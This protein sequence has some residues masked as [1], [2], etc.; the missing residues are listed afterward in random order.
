MNRN[1]WSITKFI[2]S[3]Y[4]RSSVSAEFEPRQ[5]QL[6]ILKETENVLT[7]GK[8]VLIELDCSL[9]KRY[10]QLALI[11]SVFPQK[12]IILI[13]QASTSLYE[14]YNYLKKYHKQGNLTLIDSRLPSKVR[15]DLLVA[16]QIILCLP[17]TLANTLKKYPNAVDDYDLVIINEIDQI[18]KRI[19]IS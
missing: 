9:G 3:A 18:V 1:D 4:T 8:N 5:Y 12:K 11:D 10:L 7:I 15:A 17:Q 14:T 6:K 16:N 19:S 13:L 2:Y